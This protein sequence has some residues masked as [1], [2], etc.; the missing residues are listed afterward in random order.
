VNG[1]ANKIS[2]VNKNFTGM[3]GNNFAD[4]SGIANTGERFPQ[5]ERIVNQFY[6]TGDY[7]LQGGNLHATWYEV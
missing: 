5:K 4:N 7:H 2:L 1:T 6:F 3:A